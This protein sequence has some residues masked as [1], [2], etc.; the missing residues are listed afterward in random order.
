[1]TNNDGDIRTFLSRWTESERKGD[2]ASLAP[3]LTEDFVGVG[4]LGFMLSKEA[5]LERY[6]PNGLKYDRFELDELQVHE[7][8]DAA[9]VMARLDQPGS[10]RGNPTPAAARA[11]LMVVDK[12]QGKQIAGLSLTYI[13]G[14]PGAPPMPGH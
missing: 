2:R 1:M 9:V 4:P 6:A 8:G 11:T 5:W 13:A 7:Y 3:L 14:T 10:F 12:P